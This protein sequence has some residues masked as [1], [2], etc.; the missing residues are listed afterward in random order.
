MRD[1]GH[2]RAKA[3]E[4]ES[5]LIGWPGGSERSG[6]EPLEKTERAPTTSVFA[7]QGRKDPCVIAGAAGPQG[8]TPWARHCPLPLQAHSP[9]CCLSQGLSPTDPVLGSLPSGFLLG[10]VL[11]SPGYRLRGEERWS[12]PLP[13]GV[14]LGKLC[15]WIEVAFSP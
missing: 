10:L 6:Q 4:G 12:Q 9:P 2:E 14:T 11:V 8:Q 1:R 13:L 7:E 3:K 15:P 5:E